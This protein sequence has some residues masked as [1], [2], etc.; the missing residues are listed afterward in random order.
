MLGLNKAANLVKWVK[1]RLS[2]CYLYFL[3]GNVKLTLKPIMYHS[4]V[5]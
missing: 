2:K 3:K 4:F 1:Y 5:P